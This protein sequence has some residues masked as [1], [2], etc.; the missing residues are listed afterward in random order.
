MNK[1]RFL[2]HFIKKYVPLLC[3]KLLPYYHIVSQNYLSNKK[4]AGGGDRTLATCVT[5]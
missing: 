3:Y 5:G 4:F 1:I 2:T